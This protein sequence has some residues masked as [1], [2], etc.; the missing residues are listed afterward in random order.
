MQT[1]DSGDKSPH[2]EST[3]AGEARALIFSSLGQDASSGLCAAHPI[4][5]QN[6]LKLRL[7]SLVE[8]SSFLRSLPMEA[9][10]EFPSSRKSRRS[11]KWCRWGHA[12]HLEL[13]QL[14]FQVCSTKSW[15][16]FSSRAEI[17]WRSSCKCGH[18]V[19]A[20]QQELPLEQ[21][22]HRAGLQWSAKSQAETRISH[23]I[24]TLLRMLQAHLVLLNGSC[25][26]RG[27]QVFLPQ[28]RHRMA[29]Q[30]PRPD[31]AFRPLPA[32]SAPRHTCFR[33]A[34]VSFCVKKVAQAARV[35]YMNLPFENLGQRHVRVCASCLTS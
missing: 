17:W 32:A 35:A 21:H 3:L 22:R 5:M 15:Y 31:V 20:D 12:P 14:F 27:V 30:W 34:A 23:D 16:A 24:T 1:V 2:S 28:F 33:V 7:R 8:A 19:L 18:D 6:G 10:T 26:L 13:H 25:Q 4:I 9:R 29:G 11:F